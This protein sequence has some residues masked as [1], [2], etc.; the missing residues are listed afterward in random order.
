MSTPSSD[1]SA[2]RQ[3]IRALTDADWTLDRIDN[4]EEVI[5]LTDPNID[6]PET[7]AV[8]QITA[9]DS[10]H[11]FVAGLG[12]AEGYVWFVLGNE[13]FEVAADCTVNLEPAL[14]PLTDSWF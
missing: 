12:G 11:L 10:A 13:P 2:I 1:R 9:V 3:I 5:D 4:G 8:E 14:N 6:E 7:E